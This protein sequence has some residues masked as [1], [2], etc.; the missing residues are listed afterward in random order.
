M[1]APV[2]VAKGADDVAFRIRE[3]ANEHGVPI[4]ENKPLAQALFATVEIDQ[5]IPPEHYQAVAQVISYVYK[6]KGKFAAS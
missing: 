3:V 5:Q 2:V 4:V 1:V 6:L